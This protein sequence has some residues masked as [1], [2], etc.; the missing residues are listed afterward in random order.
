MNQAL[1]VLLSH[2]APSELSR[3]LAWWKSI[4][5]S[6]SLLLAY[7]GDP[8]SFSLIEFE[9]KV[10]IQD[11]RLRV[12]DQQR[13][14]QTWTGVVEAAK[15]FLADNL[16]FN[17][18]Y[19]VEYDQVPL[20]D[21]LLELM[22]ERLEKERADVLAHHLHRVDGTS[23][24]HYL[25]HSHEKRFHEYFASVSKRDDTRVIL[26]MLGTGSFWKWEVFER[27]SAC[28]EPFPIYFELY[29]P[30]LAHHLGFRL[31]D[32]P[33]QNSFVMPLG[34]RAGEFAQARRGGAWTLHPVKTLPPGLEKTL[35]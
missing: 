8:A 32:L 27:V 21:N 10:F 17:Y 30:S 18:V 28:R 13:A 23:N 15:E 25:Y 14:R 6:A 31:R 9:P 29:L 20:V 19:L 1:V 33:D 4:L 34:D 2:Q 16:H 3:T 35:P 5:N 12:Q 22:I 7:G 26:S 24:A 11:P